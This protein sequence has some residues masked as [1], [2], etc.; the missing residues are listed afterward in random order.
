MRWST[1]LSSA[2][3]VNDSTGPQDDCSPME[4]E[5][6]ERFCVAQTA[7]R[8]LHAHRTGIHYLRPR[9]S[10][11]RVVFVATKVFKKLAV[12]EFM[13]DRSILYVCGFPAC[14]TVLAGATFSRDIRTYS[15]QRPM[16]D[17]FLRPHPRNR[18]PCFH[19]RN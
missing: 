6:P 17:L 5:R 16:D 9:R 18:L 7:R 11:S 3:I 8:Q 10:G 2:K 13:A 1:I 4:R 15:G 14:N 19:V 12:G